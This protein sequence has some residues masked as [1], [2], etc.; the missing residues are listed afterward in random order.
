VSWRLAHGLLNFS[1]A[2]VVWDC[3][4]GV[5]VVI[6]VIVVI[7]GG[8]VNADEVGGAGISAVVTDVTV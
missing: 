2:I 5:V 4:V 7:V 6:L 8:V 3:F 1:V